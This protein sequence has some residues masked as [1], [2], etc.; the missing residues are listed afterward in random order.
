MALLNPMEFICTSAASW[1]VEYNARG[2]LLNLIPLVKRARLREVVGFRGFWGRLDRHS[3]PALDPALPRFPEGTA[4][5]TP[6]HTPYMEISAGLDNILRLVRLEY[7]WRLTYRHVP[8]SIDRSGLR[9]ALHA[10]F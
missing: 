6:D 3:D 4:R 5:L 10:T 2:A 7:Y 1:E 9:I 8:Y